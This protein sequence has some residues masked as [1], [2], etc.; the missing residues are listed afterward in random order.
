MSEA[1]HL[2]S[3]ASHQSHQTQTGVKH[4]KITLLTVPGEWRAHYT[5]QILLHPL[6]NCEIMQKHWIL[7]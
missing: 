7:V 3:Q 4:Q 5:T 2:Q 6:E 1:S